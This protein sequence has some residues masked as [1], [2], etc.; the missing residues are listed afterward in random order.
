[1]VQKTNRWLIA[2]LTISLIFNFILLNKINSKQKNLIYE[3]VEFTAKVKSFQSVYHY[4]DYFDLYVP[5][6]LNEYEDDMKNNVE[7]EVK[8]NIKAGKEV[9][10]DH[11]LFHPPVIVIV[12][13]KNDTWYFT[14]GSHSLDLYTVSS[15]SINSDIVKNLLSKHQDQ[16]SSWFKMK[17]KNKTSYDIIPYASVFHIK[18]FGQG[19]SNMSFERLTTDYEDQKFEIHFIYYNPVTKNGFIKSEMVVSPI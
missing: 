14:G 12:P 2:A 4:R 9:N 1:M 17:G 18:S 11:L 10:Y 13:P 16:L 7:V 3:D 15:S 5:S 8:W 6:A 19:Y